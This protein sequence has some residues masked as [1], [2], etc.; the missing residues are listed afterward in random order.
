MQ[1]PEALHKAADSIWWKLD[2]TDWLEAF[3]SHPQLATTPQ[4]VPNRP[5]VAEGEQ[6]G[7]RIASDD[8]KT[9]LAGQITPILKNSVISISFG[10]TGKNRRRNACDSESAPT[11]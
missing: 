2:R 3:S 4:A 10:A 9:R 1:I 7:A 11:E 8:V 5:P 6:T